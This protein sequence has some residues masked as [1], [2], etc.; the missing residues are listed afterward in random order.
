MDDA[1]SDVLVYNGVL[2]RPKD[3]EVIELCEG[4]DRKRNITLLLVTEG[5]DPDVAYR[6]SRYLQDQ[7]ERFTCIVSGYCKSAGSLLAV[8]ANELVFGMHGELGPMDIQM[9][10][11]DE[12]FET[13]SGLTVMASL[14]SLH[15]ESIVGI[16]AL[17]SQHQKPI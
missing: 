10:K 4:G 17:L 7:Y 3:Q 6:I 12:L 5:G 14:R 9:S 1:D 11:K 8:G 2:Y 15:G 16:R 13:Q